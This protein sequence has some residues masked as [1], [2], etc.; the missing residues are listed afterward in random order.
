MGRRLLTERIKLNNKLNRLLKDVEEIK[1]KLAG[2]LA[3]DVVEE[4]KA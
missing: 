3:D 2:K 1:V 4:V